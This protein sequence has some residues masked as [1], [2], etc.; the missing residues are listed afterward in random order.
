MCRGYRKAVLSGEGLETS[1]LYEEFAQYAVKH[2]I[3]NYEE[4]S[5]FMNK[6]RQDMAY[7]ANLRGVLKEAVLRLQPTKNRVLK[8]DNMDRFLDHIK[9]VC[10]TRL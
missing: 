5:Q 7:L 4:L 10:P 8:Q 9:K 6:I 3:P 2:Q 1:V